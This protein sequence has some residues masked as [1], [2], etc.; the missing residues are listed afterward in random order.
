M[1]FIYN[2]IIIIILVLCFPFFFFRS[3]R[4]GQLSSFK[5][6]WG[7]LEPELIEKF[8]GRKTIWIHGASVGE[9]LVGKQ[10]VDGLKK[11]YPDYRILFSTMTVTGNQLI[12]DNMEGIDGLIYL[13]VD[14]PFVVN[15][16]MG[17]IK[18]GLLILIET[19]IWPNL[20]KAA[21]KEGARI[22]LASGRISDNSYK[23]YRKARPLLRKVFNWI[24]IFSM[25][26][27]LDRKRI[28][29]LGA[30]EKKV[31]V[32]GNIKYDRKYD[33][34]I[35]SSAI[36]NILEITAETPL[37]VAGST[38]HDEEEQLLEV[39]KKVKAFC[40]ALKM[41]IAPRYIEE[42]EQIKKLYQEN[43]LIVEKWSE[44]K[45]KEAVFEGNIEVLILDTFGELASTYQI[46]T[47][48]FVGG[49]LIPRGGHNILEP[50]AYGKT[51]FVG[52]NMF[53][54][55]E[56]LAYF[57]ENNAIIQVSNKDEL[58]EEIIYYLKNKELL[59]EKG[60]LA[61]KLI[62]DNR[63]A[64]ERHLSE[65]DFLLRRRP[66]ILLV[67]LSAIGDVIHA[68]PVARLA[69]ERYPDAVIS[70]LVEDRVADLVALNPYI[71]NI[72]AVPRTR[73]Q[74]DFRENKGQVLRDIKEF[75]QDLQS[76]NF[77]LVVDFHGIFKSALP[78]GMT[79]APLR[80]GRADGR[81]LSTLFYNKKI[82]IPDYV[83]HKIDINLYLI[84]EILGIKSNEIDFGIK[85]GEREKEKI[86][87][88]LAQYSLQERPFIVINPF[89]TWES[90]NWFLE[91]YVELAKRLQK[92]LN[93]D[94]IFTGSPGDRE[95]IQEALKD[96]PAGIYNLAGKTNL[97]EL[98]ELYRR[99]VLYIGGDTGP[100]HLAVAVGLPVVAIMGPT[101]PG[102][103]GP[104]GSN[105][106]VIRD[107]SLS[108]LNCWQRNCKRD[109]LCMKNITVEKVF[110]ATRNYLLKRESI[111]EGNE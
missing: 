62:D 86:D 111:G 17:K 104:Y 95:E 93:Y 8:K 12:R 108:C 71:D 10:L 57:K 53:N 83:T 101:D 102:K 56:D 105:N 14:I 65:V 64:L 38:H 92:E 73:W 4:N 48:V 22:M 61:R 81:E 76:Y 50:A 45:G 41:I 58:A 82:R 11:K 88:L 16:V 43:G 78:T 25:Q 72:I 69:R 87:R 85:P 51:V 3:W 35:D 106:I 19:E 89:T 99:A 79:R 39:Y 33:R 20:I 80:Y 91:R 63:G 18:P 103:F 21:R 109:K 23:N 28:L 36:L 77:D 66:K 52:P 42:G 34:D 6:R 54:F 84:K 107:D 59:E 30:S 26:S 96:N 100:M 40:P 32:Y 47:L 74:K 5:E 46:A 70:W 94:I 110:Q 2:L 13:P 67:R 1:F 24:D 49:S 37:F 60:K 97:R 68:L 75:F 7:I 44:I 15:K 55:R 9:S 31:K 90:K 29:D 98:A 27:E